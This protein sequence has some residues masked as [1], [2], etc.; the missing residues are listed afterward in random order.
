MVSYGKQ[1]EGLGKCLSSE[2]FVPKEVSER[3]QDNSLETAARS[4][5]WLPSVKT[6]LEVLHVPTGYFQLTRRRLGI[7]DRREEILKKFQNITMDSFF[8]YKLVK[9]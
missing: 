2:V 1:R 4:V 9:T 5:V 6:S 3:H 8:S 7:K